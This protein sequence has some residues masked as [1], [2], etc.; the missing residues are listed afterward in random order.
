MICSLYYPYSLRNT[1]GARC[2]ETVLQS[3]PWLEAGL[4]QQVLVERKSIWRGTAMLEIT[5]ESLERVDPLLDAGDT[6]SAGRFAYGVGSHL[7]AG[8]AYPRLARAGH[9]G[10]RGDCG[11]LPGRH[12]R[13]RPTPTDCLGERPTGP[14]GPV[15][16][17][18]FMTVKVRDDGDAK[19]NV[20]NG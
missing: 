16:A 12:R 15:V 20:A 13:Q 14:Y 8:I 19:R 9:G 6:E 7:S 10:C 5:Q 3:F 17:R 2:Q 1:T 4:L 18:G 11:D